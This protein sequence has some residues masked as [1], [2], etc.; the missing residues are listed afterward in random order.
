VALRLKR[1]T[2]VVHGAHAPMPLAGS[3]EWAQSF[4]HERLVVIQDA[5]HYPQAEQPG[6][7]FPALEAFLAYPEGR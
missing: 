1:V 7:F 2:L 3:E 6:R 5:G 4:P